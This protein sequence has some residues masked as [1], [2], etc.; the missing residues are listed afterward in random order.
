MRCAESDSNG[1]DG[2]KESGEDRGNTAR[3]CDWGTP[4]DSSPVIV[5][6]IGRAVVLDQTLIREPLR[7]SKGTYE[8]RKLHLLLADEDVVKDHETGHWREEGGV[9]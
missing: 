8:S 1:R 7:R 3:P 9:T 5:D 4:V 6:R 2:L